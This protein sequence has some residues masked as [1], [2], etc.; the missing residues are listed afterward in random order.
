[1][2]DFCALSRYAPDDIDTDAKRKE[3]FLNGLRGDL[4]IPLS[5]AYAPNYQSLLDQPITL[6]NNIR[7]EENRK[8]KFSNG[9]NHIEHSHKR[10]QS[11]ESGGS[12]SSHGHGGHFSK[13]NGHNFNGHRSNGGFRGNHTNGHHNGHHNG[14]R[15][16][17][18]NGNNGQQRFNA[19]GKKDMSEVMC[20]KCK[21]NGH[22]ADK[23]PELK[24]IEAAKPNPFQKGHVNHLDVEELMNEP[25]A[26]MGMFPLNSISADRKS[27]V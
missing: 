16:G 27:V 14:H 21:K 1:M 4:K 25:D 19:D 9:K 17:H 10:H 2:D 23:C 24:A 13:G 12:H 20:Y 7:K 11:T 15:N 18:H 26:V 3:K 22:Y 8:R 6:D 5:V